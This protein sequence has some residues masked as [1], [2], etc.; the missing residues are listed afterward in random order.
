MVG[1]VK[2]AL[3]I[4]FM[5]KV[6]YT[7][8]DFVSRD[9]DFLGAGCVSLS[10]FPL[11]FPSTAS[12]SLSVGAGVAWV[13]GYRCSN[14]S[15]SDINLT[16]APANTT[17][18]RI[19]IIEMG[20]NSAI[21]SNGDI[22]GSAILQ[23]KEG[24][25]ASSPIEPSADPNFTKLYAVNIAANQATVVSSNIIDRR[26]LVPLNVDGSQITNFAG[27][28][29]TYINSVVSDIFGNTSVVLSGGVATKD[30]TVATQLDVT[31]TDVYFANGLRVSFAASQNGQFVTSVAST[32]YYLDYNSDGTFSFG[33]SHSI[34]TGYVSIAQV[35]TDS[36]GNILT[37]TDERPL[38]VHL[39]NTTNEI[40]IG[41]SLVTGESVDTPELI[42]SGLPGATTPS[43]YVGGTSGSAPT[44]GTFDVGD[45]VIDAP[46]QTL[47]ICTV[48]GTPGTWVKASPSNATTTT[49]GIVEVSATPASGAPVALT[50]VDTTVPR[51]NTA[52]TW[53]G[54]QSTAH[55]AKTDLYGP[56]TVHGGV[57]LTVNALA[58]P[59]GL[60]ATNAT[61]GTVGSYIAANTT[62]VYEI[63]AVSY[64]GVE[65]NASASASVTTGATAYPVNLAWTAAS[66]DT[67]Y[68]NVYKGGNF[69]VQVAGSVTTYQ[70]AGNVATTTQVPPAANET[71]N[72]QFNGGVTASDV[73][74][75]GLPGA[76]TASRYVGAVAGAAP[77]TGT[78]DAGD[79]VVDTTNL[80]HW[81]CTTAGTPGTWSNMNYLRTDVNAPNPQTVAN[82][83]MFDDTLTIPQ[84][85]IPGGGKTSTPIYFSS[86]ATSGTIPNGIGIA[87]VSG[88]NGFSG[89]A[90]IGTGL[91]TASSTAI[92][93]VIDD[94]SGN[95][96]FAGTLGAVMS[97]IFTSS[98]TFTVPSGINRIYVRLWGAG[99]GGGG[100][101][102]DS[103]YANSG[104]GGGGGGYTE[105]WLSVSPQQTLTV[106][107]GT[108]GAAG[109]NS[110]TG[111]GGNG[112][113]GSSASVGSYSAPGGSGGTGAA[114]TT[115]S[116]TVPGGAGGSAGNGTIS[117][118]GSAG[119]VGASASNAYETG[120][121]GGSSGGFLEYGAGGQGANYN[122]NDTN[123]TS[124]TKGGGGGGGG[125]NGSAGSPAST[126]YN[127][128]AGSNGQVEIMW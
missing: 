32:T 34:K 56:L 100:A 51:N 79:W 61:S 90:I 124:G 59:S 80:T 72:A 49:P 18:P 116:G 104:A 97:Q 128:A 86:F 93:N 65:T 88:V 20:Y 2:L 17:Y 71:G 127:G 82:R 122:N 35:T 36:S 107:V 103:G 121:N 84:I 91:A 21:D 110:T 109:A 53:S 41:G 78:F 83:V 37:V 113:N 42:V 102:I 120:G 119:A 13:N 115:V 76:T 1:G 111:V 38:I 19:D 24:V 31:S 69:L 62:Y 8:S 87:L 92:R 60:T 15:T 68:L 98:G 123:A 9:S 12:M 43:R 99:G 73:S 64:S 39:L 10:D 58:V 48:A 3:N 16:F 66:V 54:N 63:T 29:Q 6:I 30:A 70:D 75:S 23:I 114:Y 112:G 28:N 118:T 40:Y 47:W 101:A 7:S 117:Q 55:G 57:G 25:A 4:T 67:Q 95:A 50:T 45:Y 108:G 74:L 125:A 81:I 11:I 33:T 126:F 77:T 14:D 46:S 44:T 94:G 27:V 105:G 96:S 52:N 85:D 26:T 106:T 89:V 22:T 5:D